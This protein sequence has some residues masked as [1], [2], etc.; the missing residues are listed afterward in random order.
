MEDG[1]NTDGVTIARGDMQDT[2][3]RRMQMKGKI[4]DGVGHALRTIVKEEGFLAL[5]KGWWAN[6]LKVVPQNA[7]RFVSYE[8]FKKLFRVSGRRDDDFLVCDPRRV[9]HVCRSAMLL[10]AETFAHLPL[11]V[12]LAGREAEDRHL[13][14]C[15]HLQARSA[16][17]SSIPIA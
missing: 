9:P 5:Y 2:V 8:F 16:N 1:F 14:G 4:Y 3:R 15:C 11:L 12:H 17:R 7:I 6:T 10:P 13:E